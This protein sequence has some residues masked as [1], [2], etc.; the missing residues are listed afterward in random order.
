MKITALHQWT[1]DPGRAYLWRPT[2]ACLAA[3]ADAPV[4]DGPVT[5]LA[6]NH[7]RSAHLAHTRGTPHRAYLGSGTQLD[8][9]LDVEA[10]T[11]ALT[12]FVC[13][14]AILRSWFESDGP[15]V[16]RHVV[17]ADD[18]A[19]EVEELGLLD[20]PD[21]IDRH[22][23]HRFEAETRSDTFPGLA[24]GVIAHH[25]GFAMYLG[26]D[27]ALSDGASQALALAELAEL[28]ESAVDGDVRDGETCEHARSAPAPGDY[29]EYAVAEAAIA[30]DH[31]TESPEFMEWRDTFARNGL[32][33][34][35]FPLDLGLAPGETAPVAPL[36]MDILDRVGIDGFDKVC[37]SAGGSFLSGIYAAMA[38]TGY[39]LGCGP[40]HYGMTV[41][42][43]RALLPHFARSQGWFCAFAP[44]EID[45]GPN[46]DFTGL[47]PSAH[48]AQQRTKRLATVPVQ[49]ALA[50]MIAAG[51]TTDDVVSAPN[52]LSY[53][54]F[55]WFPG[56][57]S[58]AYDRG[59]IFT[60]EGRTANASV[61]INRDHERLYLGSQTPD[62]SF[63]QRQVHR[64]FGHLCEVIADVASSGDHRIVEPT[65]AADLTGIPTDVPT[66]T[67][68]HAPT[69]LE[70][71]RL[72]RHDH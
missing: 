28:Y 7:V 27:H 3:A 33:M 45:L 10:M 16:L 57:G 54:D 37:K 20:T 17:G 59:V 55:R 23:R 66:H 14:H 50:A 51:A 70:E 4:A 61:W 11:S 22:L 43:T 13:R 30:R 68:D 34:P 69:H 62:T 19:F 15:T 31:G 64:Y 53:I 56:D 40:H 67:D 36:E 8:G 60:G 63:A 41:L 46:A 58:P 32:R 65:D 25:D 9:T 71:H 49:S 18:V 44:V 26:C 39:E 35:T 12:A 1:P 5:F 29:L 6:E 21:A 42:N 47:L 38:I 52:L 72:A 24:F 48:T 2:P